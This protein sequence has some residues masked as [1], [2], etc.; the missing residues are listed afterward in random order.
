VEGGAKDE[1][2]RDRPWQTVYSR[3]QFACVAISACIHLPLWQQ[4]PTKD[5][6]AKLRMTRK[7]VRYLVRLARQRGILSKT[8][9]GVGGGYLTT[10][11]GAKR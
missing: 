3:I 6:A 1:R 4:Q 10:N 11:E 9:P 8:D 5:A 2:D 7:R